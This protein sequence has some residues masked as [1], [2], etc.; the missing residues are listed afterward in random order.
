MNFKI[1]LRSFSKAMTDRQKKRKGQ[2]YKT[3]NIS[4]TKR[5]FFNEI[6]NIFHVFEG[7]LFGKKNKN[8]M[9]IADT[10]FKVEAHFSDEQD[11]K[12]ISL[13]KTMYVER[14]LRSKG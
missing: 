9:K 7:L 12:L 2:K 6:K 8:L 5:A 14:A 4:R 13:Y 11:Q 1:Y 10:S 3:L